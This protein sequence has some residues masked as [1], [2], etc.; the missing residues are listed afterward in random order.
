MASSSIWNRQKKIKEYSSKTLKKKYRELS[1]ITDSEEVNSLL[2]EIRHEL[3]T[4][5]GI[6]PD[7]ESETEFYTTMGH[8]FEF[9]V[10]QAIKSFSLMNVDPENFN[11]KSFKYNDQ[12]IEDPGGAASTAYKTVQKWKEKGSYNNSVIR[13]EN[14]IIQ[15]A[16]GVCQNLI[17]NWMKELNQNIEVSLIADEESGGKGSPL[18]DLLLKI[19]GRMVVLELKWQTGKNIYTPIRWFSGV[20][21]KRL[22]GASTFSDFL[23]KNEKSYW[24]YTQNKTTFMRNLTTNALM[25]HLEQ[26]GG[27]SHDA[28]TSY[29]IGKGNVAEELKTLKTIGGSEVEKMTVRISASTAQVDVQNMDVSKIIAD[30]KGLNGRLAFKLEKGARKI[31]IMAQANGQNP[32]HAA[33]FWL[34]GMGSLSSEKKKDRKGPENYPFSF[35]MFIQQ[36]LFFDLENEASFKL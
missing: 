9:Y 35:S 28:I 22:F 10:Y 33:S 21:D 14:Q 19:G 7:K 20:A 16:E 26:V 3:L 15:A 12:I 34:S 1:Q 24:S 29:L 18:G 13:F 30:E 4:V 5:R 8:L 27:A 31:K 32:Y 6:D 11:A 2:S 25:A 36:K 17:F 23:S